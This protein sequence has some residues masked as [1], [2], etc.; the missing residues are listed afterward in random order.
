MTGDSWS[1]LLDRM[2]DIPESECRL[3]LVHA[4]CTPSCIART[5]KSLYLGDL[6]GISVNFALLGLD[7][8]GSFGVRGG[9][10]GGSTLS[11]LLLNSSSSSSSM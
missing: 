3:S 11:V 6:W 2:S 1:G 10:K 7:E 8:V 4:R 9:G 5:S